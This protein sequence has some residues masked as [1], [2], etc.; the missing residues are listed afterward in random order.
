MQQWVSD[1]TPEPLSLAI[2]REAVI[3][4]TPEK[5]IE[6]LID[7]IIQP[8]AD[9][10]FLAHK[11]TREDYL[12]MRGALI[13]LHI[14]AP[15]ERTTALMECLWKVNTWIDPKDRLSVIRFQ[16]YCDAIASSPAHTYDRACVQLWCCVCGTVVYGFQLNVLSVTEAVANWIAEFPYEE[17]AMTIISDALEVISKEEFII[18]SVGGICELIQQREGGGGA[19]RE[20]LQFLAKTMILLH[21]ITPCERTMRLLRNMVMLQYAPVDNKADYYEMSDEII[22]TLTDRCDLLLMKLWARMCD[23]VTHKFT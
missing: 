4:S 5:Y 15:S 20:D 18:R 9:G 7:V 3:A 12:N 23:E 13:G 17:N 14:I 10:N 16:K 11:W 8:C 21:R 2:I 6:T 1:N 19:I 22:S